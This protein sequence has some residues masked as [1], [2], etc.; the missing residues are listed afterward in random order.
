MDP[1]RQ[2]LL[3]SSSEG[4]S[5]RPRRDAV[6]KGP[7]WAPW[8]R[9]GEGSPEKKLARAREEGA[10]AA[11]SLGK[12]LAPPLPWG[13]A[14]AAPAVGREGTWASASGAV[15]GRARAPLPEERSSAPRPAMEEG[16]QAME[17]R[18]SAPRENKPRRRRRTAELAPTGRRRGRPRGR[19]GTGGAELAPAAARAA[20]LAL[21]ADL[22]PAAAR[23]RPAGAGHRR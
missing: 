20:E 12:D 19:R 10:C 16:C 15:G 8:P 7:R 1:A 2:S 9:W 23:T 5:S 6:A 21:E 17:E 11:D 22:A 13:L 4:Q 3:S 14:G 18:S